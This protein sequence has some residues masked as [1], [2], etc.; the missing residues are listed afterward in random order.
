MEPLACGVRRLTD[1]QLGSTPSAGQ[2]A[3]KVDPEPATVKFSVTFAISLR[4]WSTKGATFATLGKAKTARVRKRRRI[5]VPTFT[6]LGHGPRMV[7][8]CL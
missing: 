4:P 2:K 5:V 6:R 3:V 8:S 1:E 7:C